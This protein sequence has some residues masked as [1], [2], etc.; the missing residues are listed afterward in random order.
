LFFLILEKGNHTLERKPKKRG[1]K[2]SKAPISNEKVA[3]TATCDRS[4]NKYFEVVTI[5]GISKKDLNKV[6]QGKFDKATVL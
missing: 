1:E 5:G 3:V 4:G 6:Y 2:A